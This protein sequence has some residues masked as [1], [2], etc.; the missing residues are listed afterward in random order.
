MNFPKLTDLERA[1]LYFYME[2]GQYLDHEYAVDLPARFAHVGEI[3]KQFERLQSLG[4][5]IRYL[6]W[7]ALVSHDTTTEKMLQ[8]P[9]MM[10]QRD[11]RFRRGM[12]RVRKLV[13]TGE[14][15][16][17]LETICEFANYPLEDRLLVA[18]S[19]LLRRLDA[20]ETIKQNDPL[21]KPVTE[22]EWRSNAFGEIANE[23]TLRQRI[24]DQ[25]QARN[26]DY[27]GISSQGLHKSD[28]DYVKVHDAIAELLDGWTTLAAAYSQPRIWFAKFV[29]EY[30]R[31]LEAA[32]KV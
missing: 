23:V 32:E 10:M 5:H 27:R 7:R 16:D 24:E 19:D 25:T 12:E 9:L 31:K 6:C 18:L 20:K 17:L 26:V 29:P 21:F 30:Q 11:Y 1:I 4:D 22:H 15:G 3:R 8:L 2:K 14:P 28:P 13:A